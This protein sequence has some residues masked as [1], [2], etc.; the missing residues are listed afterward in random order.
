MLIKKY[1]FAFLVDKNRLFAAKP[2][3]DLFSV[4]LWAII[5]RLPEMESMSKI[6]TKR[7]ILKI[8]M[9]KVVGEQLFALQQH[10]PHKSDPLNFPKI[11]TVHMS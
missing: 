10:F 4:D 7:V 5:E 3:R 11:Q 1:G 9:G 2:S 8:C 6:S